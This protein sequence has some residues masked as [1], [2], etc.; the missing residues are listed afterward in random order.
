LTEALSIEFRR[1]GVR[2]ADTLPGLI[3]TAILP[4][5]TASARRRKECSGSF[6]R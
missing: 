4:E 5:G 3:D 6:S 2:A 1:Y